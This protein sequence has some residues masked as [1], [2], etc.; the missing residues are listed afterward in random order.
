MARQSN[1]LA[2]IAEAATEATAEAQEAQPTA[3]APAPPARP[4]P[5]M[6][7][8]S[9]R[10]GGVA[11]AYAERNRPHTMMLPI[12]LIERLNAAVEQTGRSKAELVR[13]AVGQYLD[14]QGL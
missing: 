3:S 8:A 12:D 6:P 9:R 4:R 7:P 13:T 11:P 2:S 10:R 5:S 14:E 1:L